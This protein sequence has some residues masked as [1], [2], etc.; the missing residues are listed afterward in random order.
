MTNERTPTNTNEQDGASVTLIETGADER[1]SATQDTQAPRS[2]AMLTSLP[3]IPPLTITSSSTTTDF[4]VSFVVKL[5]GW[6]IALAVGE[7]NVLSV[8]YRCR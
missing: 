8:I 6:P 1:P 5:I 7:S 4:V 2:A 3:S